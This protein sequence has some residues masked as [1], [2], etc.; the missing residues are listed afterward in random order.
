MSYSNNLSY[1]IPVL[2]IAIACLLSYFNRMSKSSS[3]RIFLQLRFG[4][5]PS[6][7]DTFLSF[8][9]IWNQMQSRYS[10]RTTACSRS[11]TC[12]RSIGKLLLRYHFAR[13]DGESMET[14]SRPEQARPL[15]SRIGNRWS[16]ICRWHVLVVMHKAPLCRALHMKRYVE[17]LL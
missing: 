15:K 5:L 16:Q 1:A 7:T 10:K 14:Q 2:P 3:G 13:C 11:H 6:K 9:W 4:V 8:S 12:L 17:L